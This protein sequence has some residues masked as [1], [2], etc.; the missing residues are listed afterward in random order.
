MGKFFSWLKSLWQGVFGQFLREVFTEA[1]VKVVVAL[2]DIAIEA[3][4]ELA[5]T[6][7]TNEAKRKQ[8]FDKIKAYAKEKGIEAGES[9]VN[10]VLEMAVNKL[11]G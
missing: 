10:L 5:T 4:T 6:N 11:K 9:L 8:A 3:V 7:I 2:K 1:K